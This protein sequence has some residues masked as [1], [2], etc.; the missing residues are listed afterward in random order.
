MTYSIT[1]KLQK[2]LQ[3]ERFVICNDD[4]H[5]KLQTQKIL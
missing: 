3:T 1:K 4:F 2:K 5:Y